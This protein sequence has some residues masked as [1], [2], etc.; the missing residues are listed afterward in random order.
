MPAHASRTLAPAR[1]APPSGPERRLLA[2]VRPRHR[3]ASAATPAEL[4]ASP[5]ARPVKLRSVDSGLAR[6]SGSVRGAPG[7]RRS[8]RELGGRLASRALLGGGPED[9]VAIAV[10]GERDA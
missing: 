2:P 7:N 4:S 8:Y 1:S 5:A 3:P 10:Q 6:T 9:G